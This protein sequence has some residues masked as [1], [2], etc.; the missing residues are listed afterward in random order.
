ME[1]E[2]VKNILR[3]VSG[4]SLRKC[5]RELRADGW[6]V[7]DAEGNEFKMD[8]LVVLKMETLDAKRTEN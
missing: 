5:R 1:Y 7:I 2:D 8:E 6:Y 4:R 3:E